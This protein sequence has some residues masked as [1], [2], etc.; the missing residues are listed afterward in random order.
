MNI[1]GASVTTRPKQFKAR[2]HHLWLKIICSAASWAADW[3]PI[4][5]ANEKVSQVVSVIMV[6][7]NPPILSTLAGIFI[8]KKERKKER[9]IYILTTCS[10]LSLASKYWT[11]KSKQWEQENW[12]REVRMLTSLPDCYS[13]KA[14][15]R[16]ELSAPKGSILCVPGTIRLYSDILGFPR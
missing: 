14:L 9:K 3:L 7:K 6:Q 1:A 2:L 10:S 8:L 15:S 13:T 5:Q 16:A 4:T 12:K 11:W